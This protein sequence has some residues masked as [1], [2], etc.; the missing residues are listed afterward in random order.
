MLTPEAAG[1]CQGKLWSGALVESYRV[2]VGRVAFPTNQK[3]L[4]KPRRL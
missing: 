4:G 3:G 2:K 1:L